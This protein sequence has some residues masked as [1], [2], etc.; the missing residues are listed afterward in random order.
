MIGAHLRLNGRA[1]KMPLAAPQ[2]HVF[3]G[4]PVLGRRNRAKACRRRRLDVK[5]IPAFHRPADDYS[6]LEI[7]INARSAN[8]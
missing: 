5:R 7:V 1:T 4:P 6:K 8:G 2:G 3:L